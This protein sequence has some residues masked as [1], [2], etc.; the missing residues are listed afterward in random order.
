MKFTYYGHS[1]FEVE[2]MGKKLLFDPFISPNPL[3]SHIDVSKLMPD[4]ILIS[5]GHED[6]LADAEQ[7][8][9]QSSA[10]LISNFEIATWF[11]K[12]GLE[13]TIGMNTGGKVIRD[14]IGIKAIFA[15]HS[16]SMPDGSY[17]G[18]PIGF[19]IQSGEGNFYYSGDTALCT[20]MQLMTLW[21]DLDFAVFPIGDC[22][23]MGVEDAIFA[24]DFCNVSKVV[25]VHYDTFPPIQ[26]DKNAAAKL[27]SQSELELL[28][29]EIGTTIEL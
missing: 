14:Q 21:G 7:I 17:G 27:F 20:D 22:F 18:M 6:H 25:G 3:A 2:L 19:L 29:P 4:Y 28:L 15:Q 26:I 11:S 13:K 1:C 8:A 16:S 12:K 23:T 10:T 5:H 24:A 9:R